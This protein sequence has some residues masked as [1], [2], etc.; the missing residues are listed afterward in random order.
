[1]KRM[2]IVCLMLGQLSLAPAAV[3]GHSTTTGFTGSWTTTDCLV[4]WQE[5][6]PPADDCG[7]GST[8]YL[9]IGPG[10]EPRVTFQDSYASSC[11]NA[12]SPSF[13]WIGAGVGAYEDIYLNVELS[14]T[15]CGTFQIG[16]GVAFQFYWD[17]GSDTV[18]EDEDGDGWGYVWYR[19]R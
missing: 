5:P 1:M 16:G 9:T 2:A 19:L 14:K 8:M 6:H 3:A 4:W 10:D 18:W 12:G 15:G 13:R 17:A 11:V 7:D